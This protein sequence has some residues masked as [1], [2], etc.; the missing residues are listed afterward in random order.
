MRNMFRRL[1]AMH[2]GVPYSLRDLWV[3]G[4]IYGGEKYT[5]LPGFCLLSVSRGNGQ[6]GAIV[7][8]LKRD[9]VTYFYKVVGAYRAQGD[10]HIIS[11]WSFDFTYHHSEAL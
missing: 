1:V 10:D 3:A 7:P 4:A 5:K 2:K 8:L 9:G 6:D 11:P